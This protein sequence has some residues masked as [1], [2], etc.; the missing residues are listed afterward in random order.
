MPGLAAFHKAPT[1]RSDAYLAFIRSRPCSVT[2]SSSDVV[3]HHVRCLGGGGA[4][5]KPP[6]WTCVPLTAEEHAYLHARGE[7]S[8]WSAKG[9]NPLSEICM[10]LL[11]Y[12]AQRPSPELAA[13]LGDIVG[14]Y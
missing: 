8:Y 1:W 2:G 12:L 13:E 7:S 11:V 6:D 14:R 9:V 5:L 10:N 4:G 3:A